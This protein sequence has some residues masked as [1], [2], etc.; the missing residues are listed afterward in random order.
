MRADHASMAAPPAPQRIALADGRELLYYDDAP[1]RDRTAVDTRDL[2]RTATHSE[3]RYDRL[4]GEWVIVASHRQ[5]RTYK[6]PAHLCPL[7]PSTPQ[8][9]TEI[10]AGDYDVAV[11]ENRFPSLAPDAPD[12]DGHGPT[13]PTAR[14]AGVGR[15]EVM[16]FS[17]AHTG[18]LAGQP[19]ER[20]RTVVGA[21]ADRTAQLS[22]RADV[23]QVFPFENRGEDIGVTLHHPHGQ[24]YA[25]PFV[26]PRL[27]RTLR[28][29]REHHERT[30]GEL[31]GDLLADEH[32]A[33]ARMVVAGARWSAFVPAFARWP[34]ELLVL[35]H[36]HVPDLAALDAAE[37]DELADL[38]PRVLGAFDR[39]FDDP[40]P[41]VAGWHQAPVSHSRDAVRLHLQVFSPRRGPDKLKHL[42]GS[43]SGAGVWINDIAPESAAHHL[44]EAAG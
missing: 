9:P 30:G 17:S 8:A 11:F 21:W 29:A 2:P 35:P 5:S 20:L 28:A 4:Q 39:L 18:S 13:V 6:P 41:Y 24:I 12:P 25:Y 3:L 34:Y 33:G 7:C 38:L 14:R 37:R 31:F 19:R 27:A 15:C 23:E 16:C 1:G 26:T 40:A 43:E 32:A 42:A 22:A 10:P 36:R 44:A